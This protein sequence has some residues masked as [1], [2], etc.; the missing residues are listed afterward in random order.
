[1]TSNG[2]QL[3]LFADQ[4]STHIIFLLDSSGSM[5][6]MSEQVING[7]NE[8]LEEQQKLDGKAFMSL[9]Q[10]SSSATVV[11]DRLELSKVSRMTSESYRT[12]GMTALYDAIGNAVSKNLVNKEK[13][14]LVI[15][16]DGQENNSREYNRTSIK[17]LL[18]K[19]KE[20]KWEVMFLGANFDV[21]SFTAGVGLDKSSTVSYSYSTK[22]MS[23][24]MK[25][26][27]ARA[28]LA[29]GVDVMVGDKLFK[30]GVGSEVDMTDLYSAVASSTTDP[31][32]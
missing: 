9:T 10:F 28:S 31:T 17:D 23:D 5:A 29:R 24:T 21:D 7:Y 11:H 19:A 14:I 22:G 20:A 6:S 12:G 4:I 15:F 18:N 25:T 3:D 30:S 1:M 13:V 16:T 27:S 2:K 8:F 32:S 26:I